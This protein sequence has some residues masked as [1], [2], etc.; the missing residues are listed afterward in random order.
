[1]VER[2][3]D[4]S[5]LNGRPSIWKVL[6]VLAV[7]MLL[8]SIPRLRG[9]GETGP[10]FIDQ[11]DY[12]LEAWWFRDTSRL[13]LES[14]PRWIRNPPEQASEEL[15]R[16]FHQAEGHPMV[17]GRPL[18]DVLAS[19]PMFF[20]GYRPYIGN[21]VSA[22]FGILSLPAL[23][24][25]YRKLFG[26]RGSLA[27]VALFAFMGVH[28]YYSRNFFP[29]TDST[30]FL[31]VALFFYMKS[32]DHLPKGG[33]GW[34]ALCGFAWGLAIT[35]SDR[36]LSM[37]IVLWFLEAYLLVFEKKV[38][39]RRSLQRFL[40]LHGML[41]LPLLAIELPYVILRFIFW[42]EDAQIPFPDYFRLLIKHFLI[43]QAMAAARFIDALPVSGF[44]LSDL[45]IFPDISVRY[46]GLFYTGFLLAGIARS[47]WKR[48]IGDIV[49][50]TCFFAPII[51]LH[52]QAYHC[53]RHYSMTFPMIAMLI[54]R[55]LFADKIFEK[56]TL[57][58]EPSRH[59][60]LSQ[61]RFIQAGGW[62]PWHRAV[63]VAL[64][65]LTLGSGLSASWK[66]GIY[67][68]S[69]PETAGKILDRSWKILATSPEIFQS[70]LGTER[71][72][73]IPVSEEE[74]SKDLGEGYRYLVVDFLPVIWEMME[75]V[76][77]HHEKNAS[78][79]ALLKKILEDNQ[80]VAVFPNPGVAT[81]DVT[82]EVLFHYS[83]AFEVAERIREAGADTIRIYRIPDPPSF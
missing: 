26:P 9:L 83:D 66:A 3:K 13:L 58:S 56:G 20:A 51:F 2:T 73:G 47:L 39:W 18:H 35:A 37:I 15:H 55:G 74:L 46:N 38:S 45:L 40:A 21:G 63:L 82:L 16:I 11:A 17:L 6:A 41:L 77:I 31:I 78:R 64:F 44:R 19:I 4:R 43:A 49:M 80:P 36:W 72:R 27:A 54:A 34:I 52:L 75:G 48:R 22:F 57:E 65:L 1:M 79:L 25:L 8:G 67:P 32:R 24:L 10:Y 33:T 7:L 60:P 76:G 69:Y 70:Y 29:E 42:R 23:F 28:V 62:R 53:M 61:Q 14:I 12:M 59:P 5:C 30:F 71:C 81:R 68:F 50:L